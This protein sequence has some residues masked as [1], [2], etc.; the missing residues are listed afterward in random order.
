M[1]DLSKSIT[2]TNP[3]AAGDHSMFF[4]NRAITVTEMRI[5]VRGSTPS[6]TVDIRH[7]TDR[8]AA[9]AAL[10]TSP[11]ATT[12]ESTGSDITSFDDATIVADSFIWAE[13]DAISGDVEEVHI[14][15]FY[16]ID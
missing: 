6:A 9:G 7:G 10:I 8:S 11:S 16:T 3:V 5:V 13:F 14:T 12:S 2:I 1:P 15:I 4:S